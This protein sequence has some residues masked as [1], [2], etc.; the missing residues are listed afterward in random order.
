MYGVPTS[1]GKSLVFARIF[2]DLKSPEN[3]FVLKSAGI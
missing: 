3:E 2:E 1:S